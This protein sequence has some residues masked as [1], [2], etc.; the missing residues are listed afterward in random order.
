MSE[1]MTGRGLRTPQY[2]FAAAAPRA[3]GWKAVPASRAYQEYMLYDLYADPFQQV[4]LSGRAPYAAVSAQLGE[5]LAQRIV[6]ASG[7]RAEVGAPWFP[8][9]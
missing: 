8:Y 9:S 6:E 7:A 2:A 1:Y 4:N 5:R 3:A